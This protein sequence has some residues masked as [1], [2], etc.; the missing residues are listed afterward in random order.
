MST[1]LYTTTEGLELD[2]HYEVNPYE[3]PIYNDGVIEVPAY[4][5]SI[6]VYMVAVNGCDIYD[7]LSK[8]VITAIEDEI[9]RDLEK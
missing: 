7:I 2:C 8:Y 9:L 3:P 6:D 4:P 5:M 1:Y